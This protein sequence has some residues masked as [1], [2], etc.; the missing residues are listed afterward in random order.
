VGNSD[1]HSATFR[2]LHKAILGEKQVTF[3][4]EG[5]PRETCP[6][7]LGHKA[8]V[9]KLLAFQFGGRSSTGRLDWKCFEV[10]KVRDVRMRDGPWHGDAAHRSTQR[11]VDD[12]YID[13]NTGVPNQPGR[14]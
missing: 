2:L 5:L 7:I 4:Y 1:G 9:E 3:T 8:G 6:Y 12:V 10:A 11:C 13:V 14:R